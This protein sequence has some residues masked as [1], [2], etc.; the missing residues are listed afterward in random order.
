MKKTFPVLVN[1]RGV[2]MTKSDGGMVMRTQERCKGL[3]IE[4]AC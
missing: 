4:M 2:P 3:R 1:L